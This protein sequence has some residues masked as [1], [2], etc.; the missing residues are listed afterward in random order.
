MRRVTYRLTCGA[1]KSAFQLFDRG[2]DGNG[3]GEAAHVPPGE[4][5]AKAHIAHRGIANS[6]GGA[7]ES[8]ES[9]SDPCKFDSDLVSVLI[10][11]CK[12]AILS[13]TLVRP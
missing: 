2:M 6:A 8:G 12:A 3:L 11:R 10:S 9:T 7:E 4:R 5:R 1:L 13:F